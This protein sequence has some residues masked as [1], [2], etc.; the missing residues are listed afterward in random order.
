M[1][2]RFVR[3][4]LALLSAGALVVSLLVAAPPSAAADEQG[5]IAGTIVADSFAGVDVR[6]TVHVFGQA[7]TGKAGPSFYLPVARDASG[8]FRIA[9]PPGV[10]DILFV[11]EYD[12]DEICLPRYLEN[13]A[14]IDAALPITVTAGVTTTVNAVFGPHPTYR[15]EGRVLTSAG[16]PVVGADVVLEQDFTGL[17]T[18]VTTAADGRYALD[19]NP[20][21]R[22][23]ISVRP[24]NAALPALWFADGSFLGRRYPLVIATGPTQRV[25]VT[26]PRLDSLGSV[27]VRQRR[28]DGTRATEGW[29]QLLRR[30]GTRWVL[31]NEGPTSR[32]GNVVLPTFPGLHLLREDTGRSDGRRDLYAREVCGT[33]GATVYD[34][35]AGGEVFAD[36][37]L[38][39][40][41]MCATANPAVA[42]TRKVGTLLR[43]GTQHWSARPR[44]YS[45]RWYRGETPIPRAIHPTYRVTSA[46]A[47]QRLHVRIKANNAEVGTG[48]T[49][50]KRTSVI[51]R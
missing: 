19:A 48:T 22:Y 40:G 16:D 28:I 17:C 12:D 37:R 21:S 27:R 3:T 45:Y 31:V 14:T 51:R 9:V 1:R 42:G 41:Q 44:A 47:G 8:R 34:V 7:P 46:D 43:L 2:Q 15:V 29:L 33:T 13:E 39:P 25:D 32:Y 38:G 20:G 5:S 50:S 35:P 30:S 18:Q 23:E 11:N 6:P 36:T 26:I 10:Y 49:V 24:R 4:R